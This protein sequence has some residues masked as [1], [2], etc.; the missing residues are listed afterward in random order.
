MQRFICPGTGLPMSLPGQ[1]YVPSAMFLWQCC[2]SSQ[3]SNANSSQLAAD[4]VTKIND[5]RNLIA[6]GPRQG[7]ETVM[8]IAANVTRRYIAAAAIAAD[9]AVMGSSC[10]V[11]ME[12]GLPVV[13]ASDITSIRP[14][15]KTKAGAT[16][17]GATG[18]QM[19]GVIFALAGVV[20]TANYLWRRKTTLNGESAAYTKIGRAE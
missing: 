9:G 12:N 5:Y 14:P 19:A 6:E 3:G 7:F 4:N 1:W 2:A 11:D 8:R 15:P 18:I 16:K 17:A 20:Y 10:V 13:V